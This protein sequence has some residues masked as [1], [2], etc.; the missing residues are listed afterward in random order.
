MD[1]YYNGQK[2]SSLNIDPTMTVGSLKNILRN[3][4]VPQGV[5]NYTV[6]LRFN[7]NTDLAPV[8]FESNQY[9]NINFVNYTPLLNGGSI[10]ITTVRQP[11][12]TPPTQPTGNEYWVLAKIR[13]SNMGDVKADIHLFTTRERMDNRVLE[14]TRQ[15][16][17]DGNDL[18]DIRDI[19]E[20]GE[21]YDGASLDLFNHLYS[22]TI[23]DVTSPS[24]W[25][26]L[27][28]NTR[29]GVPEVDMGLYQDIHEAEAAYNRFEGYRREYFEEMGLED[30]ETIVQIRPLN[31][32]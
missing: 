10:F 28:I 5:T 1:L 8:V 21:M 15:Y 14:Y 11:D 27:N 31:I 7:N 3:W 6:G 16:N 9:D 20:Y 23:K 32:T 17:T 22:R 19:I 18:V 24:I 13:T 2:L 25:V 12:P 29:T 30:E 26:V 4:L